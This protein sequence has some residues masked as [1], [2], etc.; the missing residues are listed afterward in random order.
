MSDK[1]KMSKNPKSKLTNDLKRL[2]KLTLTFFKFEKEV[3]K[4]KV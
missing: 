3:E 1:K 2:F 4:R